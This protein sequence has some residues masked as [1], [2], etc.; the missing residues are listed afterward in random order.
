MAPNSF[1]PDN[2]NEKTNS[3]DT[4]SESATNNNYN[5]EESY[6]GANVL[7][8]TNINHDSVI[9]SIDMNDLENKQVSDNTSNDNVTIKTNEVSKNDYSIFAILAFFIIGIIIIL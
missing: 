5:N 9:K 7:P 6:L 8:N 3:K 4:T 2:N 1:N